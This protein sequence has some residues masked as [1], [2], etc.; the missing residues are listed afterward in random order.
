MESII[1]N[2]FFNVVKAFA[3]LVIPLL[4]FSYATRILLDDGLGKVEFARSFVGYFVMLAM[5][6]IVNY[7]TREGAKI[8]D[9]K[10]ALSKLAQEISIINAISVAASYILLAMLM[11]F[12]PRLADY[13]VLIAINSI[14]IFLTAIGFEWLYNAVEDYKY[15]AI[16]TIIFQLVTFTMIVNFVRVQDDIYKYAFILV[17]SSTGTNILNFFHSKKYI[18]LRKQGKLN[19]KK[20]IKPI[21]VLFGMTFFVQIFSNLDITMLGFMNTDTSVGL[22][23]VATKMVN[24]ICSLLVAFISVLMPRISYYLEQG[25]QDAVVK[26]SYRAIDMLL[27]VSLPSALGLCLLSPQIIVIFSGAA[28]GS[29][30][31]SAR[32]LSVRVLL[33]PLN[34][35]YIV[36][37]F[38]PLEKDVQNSFTTAMA[39]FV[40]IF[41]NLFLIPHFSQNG[42]AI[43]TIL[44][45]M[46]ELIFNL[47]FSRNLLSLK[48]TYKNLKWY[49]LADILI[50]IIWYVFQL[51]FGNSLWLLFTIAAAV[52]VYF[53]FLLLC[54]CDTVRMLLEFIKK[55]QLKDSMH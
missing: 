30:L 29:A 3:N 38:I 54:K 44:A 1:K 41:F 27:M 17:L 16:R 7:A 34:T 52:P 45:E 32:V 50:F 28:F 47:Y 35:F 13:K 26:L 2:I 48:E 36:Q 55:K 25:K 19:I 5:L 37:L 4:T 53:I 20:H 11:I 6:G 23:S 15:I 43:A 42:A 31:F 18:T 39:A 24:V 51:M 40:N 46:V 10:K 8:R 49:L 9:D 21:I 22:Y 12:I 14:S 33:S